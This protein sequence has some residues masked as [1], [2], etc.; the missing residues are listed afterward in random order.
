MA[1]KKFNTTFSSWEELT[2]RIPQGS[3]LG[4][5]LFNIYLD[6]LFYQECFS[7]YTAVCNFADDTNFYA[8]DEK[9]RSP[10]INR[11]E[12]DSCAAPWAAVFVE[13]LKIES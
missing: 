13:H 11:L 9:C 1:Q 12:H 4:H 2:Q 6:D 7:E 3:V 10:F 5:L 8:R